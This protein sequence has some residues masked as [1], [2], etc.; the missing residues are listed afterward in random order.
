MTEK[1]TD[2]P[3]LRGG[4]E[5]LASAVLAVW[6]LHRRTVLVAVTSIAGVAV[7]AAAAGVIGDLSRHTPASGSDRF[8]GLGCAD[9]L[10]RA[11]A[12]LQG[13]S[14]IAA[15]LPVVV[16]AVIGV[17]TIRRSF[18]AEAHPFAYS[19]SMTRGQWYTAHHLVIF[20]PVAAAMGL[21]GTVLWLARAGISGT[22][23]GYN[24]AHTLEYPQFQSSPLVM[25]GYT[26][27][28]L[29][30]VSTLMLIVRS[31]AVAVAAAVAVTAAAVGVLGI[32]R[33]YY[34][35][36]EVVS[37]PVL[38]QADQETAPSNWL[39]HDPGLWMI[40]HGYY[41]DQGQ[42]IDAAAQFCLDTTFPAPADWPGDLADYS[43]SAR[44]ECLETT[45][46]SHHQI[47]Y[48]SAE[49]TWW[50]QLV[51]AGIMFVA[52]LSLTIPARIRISKMR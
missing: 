29:A 4:E 46:V 34:A 39:D 7:L 36:A 41:T 28:M 13:L 21:L 48:H 18:S 27:A 2:D 19:Q 40:D 37:V 51:E 9:N 15:A 20:I 44:N 31:P 50:F 12:A 45:G 10:C 25:A 14:I 1:L 49:R 8:W 22:P 32:V 23:W 33:P 38:I 47:S 30:L 43:N 35:T 3:R 26:Y 5:N 24:F 52:A 11:G 16:G 42:R 6:V 17:V